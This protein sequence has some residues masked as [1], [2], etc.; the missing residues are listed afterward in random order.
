MVRGSVLIADDDVIIREMLEEFLA[1]EGFDV[2]TASD[3]K[4]AVEQARRVHPDCILMDLNMPVLD[5]VSAIRDLKRDAR[6]ESIRIYAMSARS[7]IQSHARELLADGTLKK[8]FDLWTV[9]ETVND[10]DSV[11]RRRDA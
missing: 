7:V 9:L 8:P 3:G 5:G 4:Q 11:V 2:F 6:T 1:S 10:G